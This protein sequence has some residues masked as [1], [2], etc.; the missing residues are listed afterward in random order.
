MITARNRLFIQ[1][2][3]CSAT[4]LPRHAVMFVRQFILALVGHLLRNANWFTSVRHGRL[5]VASL[6]VEFTG[7][8]RVRLQLVYQ[9]SCGASWM[10]RRRHARQFGI[11]K[12]SARPT[13]DISG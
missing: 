11:A 3:W 9:C 1:R 7:V 4:G 12:V 10:R 8:R 6:C 5:Q 2:G 13:E